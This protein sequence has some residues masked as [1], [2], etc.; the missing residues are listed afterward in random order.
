MKLRTE[1]KKKEN[2]FSEIIDKNKKRLLSLGIILTMILFMLVTRL[3]YIQIIKK[4]DYYLKATNQWF[5]EIPV[6]VARGRIYD[7]NMQPLTNKNILNYVVIFPDIFQKTDSNLDIISKLTGI[8]KQMLRYERLRGNR[9]VQLQTIEMSHDLMKEAMGIR[10]VYPLEIEERYD[11]KKLASH[12]IGYINKIDNIGFQ[13]LERY[14]NELLIENQ[15]FKI[16][17]IVDAQKRIIPGLGY[18]YIQESTSKERKNIVTTIDINI[19]KIIE[20]EFDS[21]KRKG[22]IVVLNAK[23]GDLL[24]MVSRPNFNQNDVASHLNSSEQEFFNRAI[25]IAYPPGSVFKIVLAAAALENNLIAPEQTYFCKGYEA[26]EENVI[27][28]SS[29]EKDGHGWLDLKSAFAVSCN[30]YFIQLGKEI[31]GKEILSMAERLG[32]GKKTGIELPEEIPGTLP[33]E[34]YIK[35]AGIGNTSIGQGVLGVTPLQIAKMTAIIANDGIDT[36]THLTKEIVDDD[37]MIVE[38]FSSR[39]EIQRISKNT[40]KE[41]QKM[42]EKVVVEGTARSANSI[43]GVSF[44]GKTGSAEAVSDGKNTVHAWFTGYF[45][46]VDPKYVIT[47]IVEDGGSG[48]RV[49]VPLFSNI[50]ERINNLSS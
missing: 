33:D 16:G 19:Q 4:E 13:G 37:G 44:A 39:Q 8:D 7:R 12:L 23:N 50:A 22:S 15:S 48:G 14:Y 11:E 17:A 35:G 47:I 29:Y 24:G 3:A 18:K 31:G 49:A 46:V 32:F 40:A 43:D 28:C 9:P 34:D 1:R 5:K 2:G 25:Q 6:G 45:P 10:G 20:E 41:L 21:Q 36:G 38:D 27:K 30:S 26:F 42:M